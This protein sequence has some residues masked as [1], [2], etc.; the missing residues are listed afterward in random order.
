MNCERS[1]IIKDNSIGYTAL[2][3]DI[4]GSAAPFVCFDMKLQG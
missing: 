2:A 4:A 3:A 1:N